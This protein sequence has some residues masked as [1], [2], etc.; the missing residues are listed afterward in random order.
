MILCK[1]YAK[2]CRSAWCPICAKTGPTAQAIR[3]RMKMLDWRKVRHIVLTVTREVPPEVSFDRVRTSRAVAR[4][5]KLLDAGRW[6]WVL[7]WHLGGFPHWHV[8][9]EH[10]GM[11]GK[12]RIQ[13]VWRKGLVWESYVRNESHWRA[14]VGYHRQK[15]YLAGESKAH[16][17]VLPEYLQKK[18]RVRKFG[19]NFNPFPKNVPCGTSGKK[20]KKRETAP[21]ARR[22]AACDSATKINVAGKWGEIAVPLRVARDGM[23]TMLEKVDHQ[24][25]ATNSLTNLFQCFQTIETLVNPMEN[26]EVVKMSVPPPNPYHQSSFR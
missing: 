19:S 20:G 3:D 8:M 4:T 17:L 1:I 16:Q 5:M 26:N 2:R 15:G 25:F 6:L 23:D 7:E 13:E 11:I 12:H 18:S 22:I 14:L 21:Y 10:D 24:T 9:A